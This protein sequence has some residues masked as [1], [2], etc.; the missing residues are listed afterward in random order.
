MPVGKFSDQ[1]EQTQTNPNPLISQRVRLCGRCT[2]AFLMSAISSSLLCPICV[3]DADRR[4]ERKC[5]TEHRPD[6]TSSCAPGDYSVLSTR[7]HC[8]CGSQQWRQNENEAPA[9][10]SRLTV[11]SSLTFLTALSRRWRRKQAGE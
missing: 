6:V 10:R 11:A 7:T 4:R 8:T 5:V 3:A 2:S 9:S 1:P